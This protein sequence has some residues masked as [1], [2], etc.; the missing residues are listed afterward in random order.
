MLQ[1]VREDLRTSM[2]K[3]VVTIKN[4]S[5]R[6]DGDQD[7]MAILSNANER[8]SCTELP[9]DVSLDF[10][11]KITLSKHEKQNIDVSSFMGNQETYKQL[12][13][14]YKVFGLDVSY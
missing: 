12:L 4:E 1:D 11:K 5:L 14:M 8:K 6:S 13:G 10:Q 3:D 2:A 9:K 7:C